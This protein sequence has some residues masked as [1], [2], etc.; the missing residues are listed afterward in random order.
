MQIFDFR[1]CQPCC[2]E[3]LGYFWDLNK[4]NWKPGPA[5]PS[6]PGR[7]RHSWSSG[8][9]VFSRATPVHWFQRSLAGD[10]CAK[11]CLT[12]YNLSPFNFSV[13]TVPAGQVAEETVIEDGDDAEEEEKPLAKKQKVEQDVDA[14]KEDKVDTPA[15]TSGCCRLPRVSLLCW[16]CRAPGLPKPSQSRNELCPARLSP[17]LFL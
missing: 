8:L 5:F 12:L 1:F 4:A 16:G 10:I 15:C 3:I 11:A 2:G 17:G 6:S 14:S 7:L 13:L 9:L